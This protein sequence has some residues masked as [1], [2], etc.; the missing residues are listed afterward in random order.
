MVSHCRSGAAPWLKIQT[1]GV[2]VRQRFQLALDAYVLPPGYHLTFSVH[3]C[4]E[5]F[6]FVSPL[7]SSIWSA[8]WCLY[9]LKVHLCR[10]PRLLCLLGRRETP[11]E[12]LKSNL[13]LYFS[14]WYDLMKFGRLLGGWD[15]TFSGIQ[16]TNTSFIYCAMII[17]F[18]EIIVSKIKVFLQTCICARFTFRLCFLMKKQ[19][20]PAKAIVSDAGG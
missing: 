2:Y 10:I 11:G 20:K 17:Y 6:S 7:C 5:R 13:F 8:W 18:T 3:A 14:L 4:G 19:A 9:S 1:H 15:M 16:V 12:M